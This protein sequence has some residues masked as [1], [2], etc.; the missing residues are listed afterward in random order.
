MENNIN[1]TG[2]QLKKYSKYAEIELSS[3]DNFFPRETLSFLKE[4]EINNLAELFAAS[5]QEKFMRFLEENR[6]NFRLGLHHG[7]KVLALIN[8]LR[9]KY[10][11]EDPSISFEQDTNMREFLD[12]FGLS[13]EAKEYLL[14]SFSTPQELMKLLK[15]RNAKTLLMEVFLNEEN[16]VEE[17]IEKF[18]IVIYY[19][20]SRDL[21]ISNLVF[22]GGKLESF[23]ISEEK[24]Y[25][26]IMELY[27]K[28]K[29]NPTSDLLYLDLEVL[30]ERYRKIQKLMCKE[31]TKIDD[32]VTI[33]SK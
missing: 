2:N 19:Y 12:K 21:E 5:E 17:I 16:V 9:C 14:K 31:I 25:T 29:N 22:L 15:A 10:L 23:I 30:A 27:N 33:F 1:I 11:N 3:I 32:D 18:S 8:L 20:V 26:E 4:F 24:I 28:I 7:M 13:L 6:Y